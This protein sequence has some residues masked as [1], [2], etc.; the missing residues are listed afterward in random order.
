MLEIILEEAEKIINNNGDTIQTI[1]TFQKSGGTDSNTIAFSTK[2]I[3]IKDHGDCE[4]KYDLEDTLLTPGIVKMLVYDGIGYIYAILY[5][6]NYDLRFKVEIKING[7]TEFIGHVKENSLNYNKGLNTLNFTAMPNLDTLVNAATYG[8]ENEILDPLNYTT[9]DTENITNAE[10]DGDVIVITHATNAT[11]LAPN[12]VYIEG[13]HG[14][15]NINGYH[16]IYSKVDNNNFEIALATTQVYSYGGT[17]TLIEKDLS[18]YKNIKDIIEDIYQLVDSS[19]SYSGGTLDINQNWIFN[20]A[21]SAIYHTDII[22]AESEPELITFG[23]LDDDNG[24]FESA[25]ADGTD[26]QTGTDWEKH[27]TAAEVD[28][29]AGSGVTTYNGSDFCCKIHTATDINP[30]IHLEGADFDVLFAEGETYTISFD[31]K[32]SNC[33]KAMVRIKNAGLTVDENSGYLTSTS[34]TTDSFTVTCD[35]DLDMI[36]NVYSHNGAD[37]DGTEIIWV[38]NISIMPQDQVLI[39]ATDA[40]VANVGDWIYCIDVEGMTDLNDEFEILATPDNDNILVSLDTAQS[41]TT[42]G[43]IRELNKKDF[44]EI[45]IDTRWLFFDSDNQTVLNC[46]DILK[47]LAID[48][49]CFTGMIHEE[50]AF[51]YKLFYYDS[52][53]T[54]TL[55]TVLKHEIKYEYSLIEYVKINCGINKDTHNV[56]GNY[57]AL[58][59]KRLIRNTL[60]SFWKNYETSVGISGE[61]SIKDDNSDAIWEAHDDEVDND[62]NAYYSNGHLLAELWYNNRSNIDKCKVEFFEIVGINYDFLKNFT[63]GGNKYQI[64]RLRKN[65]SKNETEIDAINLGGM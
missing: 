29:E 44:D 1:F 50:K 64:M 19:I 16:N 18:L 36:I 20:A 42:G 13:V 56:S 51:F 60:P 35:S 10:Y 27:N 3:I 38:D 12:S 54:Q 57:T 9:G 15:T 32:M 34:W 11:F 22:N 41:Y 24:G 40:G 26:I 17:A 7:T 14:M 2:D 39:N 63:Y 53:N 49:F 62:N 28:N 48:W 30:N 31:Y 55:G 61:S 21:G 4:W 23:A 59:N 25:G 43:E 37:K 52:G 46:G 6:S 58:E 47:K 5:D 65:W 45:E 8:D 33:T